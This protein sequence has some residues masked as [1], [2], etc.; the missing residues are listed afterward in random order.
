MVQPAE[1][2]TCKKF[3][4]YSPKWWIYW[5][6]TTVKSKKSP[7]TKSKMIGKYIAFCLK[8]RLLQKNKF[9]SPFFWVPVLPFACWEKNFHPEKLTSWEIEPTACFSA[10][11]THENLEITKPNEWR[12]DC[13]STKTTILDSRVCQMGLCDVKN[14]QNALFGNTSPPPQP[15]QKHK[16]IIYSI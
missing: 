9:H 4:K 13:F 5:W 3:Q 7:Q 12:L 1:S 15:L 16:N 8:I 11:K 6:F 10:E 14:C 2:T